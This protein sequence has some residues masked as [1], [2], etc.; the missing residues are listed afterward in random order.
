MKIRDDTCFLH[1]E[2]VA[3]IKRCY[4]RGRVNL[5]NKARDPTAIKQIRPA[6]TVLAKE[7]ALQLH[8]VAKGEEREI[9]RG[10]GR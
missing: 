8:K 6:G 5:R 9:D 2:A 7:S 3:S 10:R 4:I 1:D